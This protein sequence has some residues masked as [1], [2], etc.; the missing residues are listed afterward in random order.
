MRSEVERVRCG[1]DVF[2]AYRLARRGP[3]GHWG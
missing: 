3:E 1:E 2:M